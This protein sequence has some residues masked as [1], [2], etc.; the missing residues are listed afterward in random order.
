MDAKYNIIEVNG[1]RYV[2]LPDAKRILGVSTTAEL[3]Q[4]GASTIAIDDQEPL[5]SLEWLVDLASD[6]RAKNTAPDREWIDQ[7]KNM[8]RK[9]KR[10]AL[11]L[12]PIGGVQL[13]RIQDL[14]K[15][16]PP[17]SEVPCCDVDWTALEH[18]VG[19][20]YPGAF[21]RFVRTYGALQWFDWLQPLVPFEDMNVDQFSAYIKQIQTDYFDDCRVDDRTIDSGELGSKG[22]LLP[23]MVGSD[24]DAYAWLVCNDAETWNVVYANHRSGVLLGPI[25]ISQMLAGWLLGEPEME[26]VW[27]SIEKF[28]EHS[29]DALQ[30]L[31]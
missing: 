3:T 1:L 14:V 11:A 2:S 8:Y 15:L 26:C 4:Y 10:G 7:Y 20:A 28:R 29:A 25:S 12:K 9:T 16:L 17:P 18:A 31:E 27:G 30:M 19:V 22:S 21:K 24:G 6:P 23:F 5:W 13:C